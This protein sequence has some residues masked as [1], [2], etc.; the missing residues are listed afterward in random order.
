M[1][2]NIVRQDITKM[3]TDAI[4]AA[5]GHDLSSHGMVGSAIANAAGT[6]YQK[7]CEKLGTCKT[8]EAKI[9]KGY[10]LPAKYVI[11][12]TGPKYTGGN[13]GEDLLLKACYENALKLAEENGCESI[14][15][16]LIST[17]GYGFPKEEGIK[18]ATD[19]IT[20]YLENTDM[21]IYLVVYDKESLTASKTLRSEIQ[22]YIDDNYVRR[23]RALRNLE[24][25]DLDMVGEA[26]VV[27][28]G[29]EKKHAA[30]TS[31]EN[32][33]KDRD[34]SFHETLFKLIKEKGMK[35]S[36]VYTRANLS[37]SHFSKIKNDPDYRPKKETVFAL[38][39]AL[40]LTLE[41]TRELM[42][43]AGYAVSHSFMLDTIVEYF[44]TNGKYNIVEI[45]I[46]LFDYDQPLLGEKAL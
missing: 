36:E 12:T 24:R 39:I 35:N 17:G 20:G 44:I 34:E 15:F 45:N 21:D 4:V 13:N 14:A 30:G 27:Y 3:H 40:R 33:I 37:K 42:K 32:F 18:I 10:N 9:T 46:T 29:L 5:E 31:L 19:T 23:N 6:D 7:E 16:P 1:P 43:K 25:E 41:E 8:G 26:P 28:S 11:H 38:A 22:E 2:L